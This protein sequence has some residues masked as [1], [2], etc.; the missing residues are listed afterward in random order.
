[1]N[2]TFI[3]LIPKRQCACNFNHFRPISLCNFY[4]KII[5]KI[6]VMSLRQILPKLIDPTQAV[7]VPEGWIAENVV[8]AQDVVHSFNQSKRKKGNV[9]LDFKKAY[10][11]L[12]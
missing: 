1:M 8:L 7:F 9:Q 5:S 10:D 3:I 2:H 11:S 6:L 4:Y 12:E